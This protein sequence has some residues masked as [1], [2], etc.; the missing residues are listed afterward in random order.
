MTKYGLVFIWQALRREGLD[1][2][3]IHTVHDEVVVE[4]WEKDAKKVEEIMEVEMTRAHDFL[5]KKVPGKVEAVVS[6]V[7]EH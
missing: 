6:D 3:P 5:I 4:C 1:A 7:W 2:Y